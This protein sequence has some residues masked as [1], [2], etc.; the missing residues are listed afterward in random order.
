MI[1]RRWR[2]FATIA[3]LGIGLSILYG[4]ALDLIREV[5]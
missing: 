1:R 5:W 4:G 2:T 3:V